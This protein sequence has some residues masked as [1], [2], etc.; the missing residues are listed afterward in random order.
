MHE[1][2]WIKTEF[3]FHAK[4]TLTHKRIESAAKREK[5]FFN[6]WGKKR[7]LFEPV[8]ALWPAENN[9]SIRTTK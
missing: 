8:L 1:R 7:D 6:F 3:E 4:I 9:C 2:E 5:P